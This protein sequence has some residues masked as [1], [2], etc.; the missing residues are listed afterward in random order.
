MVVGLKP[1]TEWNCAWWLKFG[2]SGPDGMKI[3]PYKVG[4]QSKVEHLKTG[5]WWDFYFLLKE[6]RG[7]KNNPA[8]NQCLGLKLLRP[9]PTKPFRPKAAP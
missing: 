1:P 8:A 5:P 6:A 2:S 7:I 9:M 3:A 4:K